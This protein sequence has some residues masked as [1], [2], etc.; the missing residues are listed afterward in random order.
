MILLWSIPTIALLV[1][2]FRDPAA[3]AGS[4]WWHALTDPSQFTAANYREVLNKQGMGRAFVNSIIIALPAT[5]LVVLVAAAA[6]YAF[7]WMRFPLRNTLFLLVVAMLVVPLQMTLIP[8]LRLYT[9]L[10]VDVDVPILGG[11]IFGT[12]S[13]AG[14]WLAHTA[15][16]LPFAVFLLRNFFGAL[17][18]DLFE[19]AYLDGASEFTVFRRIVLP[20]SM[21]AIAALSI[22]QFL[23]VWNDLLIALVFLGDP[24]M[25]PMTVKIQSLVSS[26]GTNYQVLTAAAFVSM[27]LPLVVFFALQRYFVQGV[28]AGAVKG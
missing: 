23:W 8:V 9:H 11:R 26:F 25:F 6:G 22:F 10:N 4:G 13:Y 16:G 2:S 28:L 20:L 7:A 15:Y 1:S 21:P 3:I 17:P 27:A 18:R 14:I 12:N 5:V 19:S 24:N